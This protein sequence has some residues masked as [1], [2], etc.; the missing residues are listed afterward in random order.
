MIKKITTVILTGILIILLMPTFIIGFIYSLFKVSFY[1]GQNRGI[2]FMEYAD[3]KVEE[4]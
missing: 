3:K 1:T 2:E 4:L